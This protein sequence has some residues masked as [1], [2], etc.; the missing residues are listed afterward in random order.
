MSRTRTYYE[1]LGVSH[2][3][4]VEVVRRSYRALVR[5]YHPD[6]LG[7]RAATPGAREDAERHIRELNAAWQV[8][9]DPERRERYDRT[10]PGQTH[11]VA[12]SP[13]PPGTE[14]EP[15]GG[16]DEWFADADRRR[17]SARVV[18]RDPRPVRP[19]RV[20]WLFGLGV[21]LVV[22]ILLIA[23]VAGKSDPPMPPPVGSGQCV[24]VANGPQAVQVPCSQPNDGRIVGH[25]DVPGECPNDAVAR[26]LSQGD[27]KVT[28]LSQDSH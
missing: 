25:V 6:H 24:Q 9:R 18:R 3:A 17:S 16:F 5:R 7:D 13:F 26:R 8:L 4:T 27:T 20:R 23:L 1:V 21:V 2:D 28:C 14:R 12:Y 10:L 11:Q 19:Y 15:P 22:G